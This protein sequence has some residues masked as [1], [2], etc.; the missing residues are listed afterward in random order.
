M[1]RVNVPPAIRLPGVRR[2]PQGD[3]E[4]F[5]QEIKFTDFL[6]LAMIQHEAAGL[7]YE[8]AVVARKIWHKL[9]SVNGQPHIDFEDTECSMLVAAVLK[10]NLSVKPDLNWRAVEFYEAV[11]D[12]KPCDPS[13]GK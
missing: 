6:L 7:G 8:N 10:P 11:R 2:T 12:A 13:T 9:E 4:T 1:K 3:L 5:D